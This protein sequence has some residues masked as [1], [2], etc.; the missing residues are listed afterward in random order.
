MTSYSIDACF[1]NWH[2]V[3]CAIIVASNNWPFIDV[4]LRSKLFKAPD[5][6][7]LTLTTSFQDKYG[8]SYFTDKK[9]KT[10][11]SNRWQYLLKAT[12]PVGSGAAQGWNRDWPIPKPSA[13]SFLKVRCSCSQALFSFLAETLSIQWSWGR[14]PAWDK[15]LEVPDLCATH[16]PL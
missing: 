3:A 6:L 15:D 14:N 8:H 7:F 10:R 1:T 11:V 16:C 12:K 4:V 13:H 2:A 9:T 5:K